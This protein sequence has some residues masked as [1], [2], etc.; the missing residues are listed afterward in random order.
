[1]RD[2]RLEAVREDLQSAG[3][4]ASIGEICFAR[5]FGDLA[6]FTRLFKSRFGLAPGE[7][8]KSLRAD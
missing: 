2:M 5:G 4:H 3:P 8:R 1:V 7:Y 6:H